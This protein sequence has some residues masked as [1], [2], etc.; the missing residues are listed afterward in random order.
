MNTFNRS[1]FTIV[2]L[3]GIALFYFDSLPAQTSVRTTGSN[4]S[5]GTTIAPRPTISQPTTTIP[6]TPAFQIP[7]PFISGSV[8]ME[9]GSSLPQD[10]V[11]ELVSKGFSQS[12]IYLNSSGFFNFQPNT[13]SN[14]TVDASS[15]FPGGS[16]QD[17]TWS[18]TSAQYMSW[19]GCEVRAKSAGYRSSSVLLHP[20]MMTGNSIQV[21]TLVLYSLSRIKGTSVSATNLKAGKE[22]QKAWDKGDKAFRMNQF[23][24]A[25]K[26]FQSAVKLYPQY[27]MAW[28]SLGQLYLQLN[29]LEEARQALSRAIEADE[30]YVNPYIE[31][32]RIAVKEK[33][34]PEVLSTTD[35]ALALNPLDFP[36]S[37]VMNAMAN[38]YLE[39]LDVAEKAV[40]K[41]LLLDTANRYPQGYLVLAS[42]LQK[43][44]DFLGERQQ[45]HLYLQHVPVGTNVERVQA[46][47]HDLENLAA[48]KN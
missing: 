22:A 35:R 3:L 18:S 47:L 45:L 20:R 8:V 32:A 48:G 38:L 6:T 13:N 30:S 31:I 23:D 25:I 9:D 2:L 11:I 27:A 34:W 36:D 21:G 33:K 17:S 41:G 29:R 39:H 16:S 26:E 24:Q 44:K 19:I 14:Q 1:L 7:M 43:K 12:G 5:P 37:Y 28:L 46:R 10:V 4:G 15:P 40:R 42:I